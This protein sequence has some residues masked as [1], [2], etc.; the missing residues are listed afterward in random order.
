MSS[1][2]LCFIGGGAGSHA[3]IAT[4]L[5]QLLQKANDGS[6]QLNVG[7]KQHQR[8]GKSIDES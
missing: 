6:T 2:L 3:V 8:V 1:V 7:V 4:R 5:K